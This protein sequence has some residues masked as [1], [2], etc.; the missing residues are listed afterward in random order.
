M[1]M[2]YAAMMPK[3]S[4]TIQPP[5]PSSSP[6]STNRRMILARVTPIAITVP[7]SPVRST[8]FIIN[9]F[10]ID[11]KM[12]MAITVSITPTCFRSNTAVLL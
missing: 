3:T 6:S 5:T 4:P 11:N 10:A 7:I 8:T 1:E 2:K 9:V 12:M